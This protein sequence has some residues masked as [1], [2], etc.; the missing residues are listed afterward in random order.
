[1]TVVPLSSARDALFC[2]PHFSQHIGAASYI[3]ALCKPWQRTS[4]TQP[5]KRTLHTDSPNF[6]Y[7]SPFLGAKVGQMAARLVSVTACCRCRVI[8]RHHAATDPATLAA[9]G[10]RATCANWAAARPCC[11]SQR[12]L[13]TPAVRAAKAY[14]TARN[15]QP[16]PLPLYPGVP[17]RTLDAAQRL[18]HGYQQHAS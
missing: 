18:R 17:R 1:M 10:H 9:S 8:C 2:G 13:Y 12:M 6:A 15:S 7:Q 5:S 14:A 11:P 16:A 4:S 3:E